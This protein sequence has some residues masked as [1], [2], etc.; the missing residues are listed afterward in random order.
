MNPTIKL[1]AEKIG[2]QIFLPVIH[3]Y[4]CDVILQLHFYKPVQCKNE[5]SQA[6]SNKYHNTLSARVRKQIGFHAI[7]NVYQ[8][9]CF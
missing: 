5:H 6:Y 4:I 1:T 3:I 9:R 8:K 2:G 7:S